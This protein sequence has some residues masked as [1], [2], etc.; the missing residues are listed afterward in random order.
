[1]KT[2]PVLWTSPAINHLAALHAYLAE[3]TVAVADS[4]V[5]II[6]NVTSSLGDIPGK[7]RTGRRRGTRELV[8]LGTPYIVAYRVTNRNITILAVIHGARTWPRNFSV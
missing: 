3:S 8:V 1:M 5:A 4:Q 6:L 2:E 7:G